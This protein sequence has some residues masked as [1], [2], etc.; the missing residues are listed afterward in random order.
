MTNLMNEMIRAA[1]ARINE[2]G[3]AVEFRETQHGTVCIDAIE[4]NTNSKSN[5]F[6][7]RWKLNGKAI[8]AAKLAAM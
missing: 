4:V 7:K 3:Y 1:A 8:S 2:K 6:T 5:Q